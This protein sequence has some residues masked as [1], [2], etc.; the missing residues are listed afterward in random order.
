MSIINNKELIIN[1]IMKHY[2]FQSDRAF[3]QFLGITPQGLSNW[4]VRKTYDIEILY[5]KC[6]GINANWLLT[7]EGEMFLEEKLTTAEKNSQP[8]SLDA[9]LAMKVINLLEENKELTRKNTELEKQLAKCIESQ[10]KSEVGYL[11]TDTGR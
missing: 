1:E 9:T 7:G 4:R 5:T 3:A 10:G 11:A 8:N 2:N 6:V